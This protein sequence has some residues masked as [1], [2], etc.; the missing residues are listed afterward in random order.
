[1][2]AIARASEDAPPAAQAKGSNFLGLFRALEHEHGTAAVARVK[3]ALGGALAS[4]LGHGHVLAMGWY[5]AAWYAELHDAVAR[6]LG[7]G[8]ELARA[9]GR[10]ATLADFNT[11]HRL[12]ASMLSV[13][14]V[15]G[16]THRLM[17]LYWKG[18]TIEVAESI[19]GQARVR[20]S[21]WSGFSRLVW[22]DLMG[23][24]E[25]VLQFCGAQNIRCRATGRFEDLQAL[26]LDVRWT[27]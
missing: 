12:L 3:D 23:S 14:T 15:F 11:M 19:A 4:E 7:S 16:Q 1:M 10:R 17:G 22:E 8:P 21:G 5:P 27:R 13:E 24:S 26:D 6:T 25:A 18:G 2:R 20:F 9:L